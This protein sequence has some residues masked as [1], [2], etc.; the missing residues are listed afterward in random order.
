MGTTYSGPTQRTYTVSGSLSDAVDAI[1]Q[2]EEAGKTTWQVSYTYQPG[3]DGNIASVE[4]TCAFAI[5][6]PVWSGYSSA[7]PEEQAEWDRF[8]AALDA[9][10]QG[11]VQIAQYIMDT[12]DPFFV[13]SPTS[14]ADRIFQELLTTLQSQ[15]D[16]FDTDTNHGINTG[17]TITVP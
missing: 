5:E 15:S 8:Y 2:R 6:M 17:C 3:D 10:E 16:A 1:V 13:G 4:F 9:H 7:T 11:H 12:A 14:D